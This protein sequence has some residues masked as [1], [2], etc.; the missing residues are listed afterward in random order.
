MSRRYICALNIS[1]YTRSSTNFCFYISWTDN[2]ICVSPG[3][4]DNSF[5][6]IS[7]HL[8][9]TL[10]LEAQHT[11]N[12]RISFSGGGKVY[13]DLPMQIFGPFAP[14]PPLSLTGLTIK[15]QLERTVRDY[16]CRHCVCK[17]HCFHR[18]N[19]VLSSATLYTIRLDWE[20][21]FRCM[22][23][24]ATSHNGDKP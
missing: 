20:C 10:L 6:P 18:Y 1:A 11:T 24:T 4:T 12:M 5:L 14:P 17:S 13:R 15:P 21:D 22:V 3:W 2:R 7:N 8:T 16:K 23:K 19:F 9:L